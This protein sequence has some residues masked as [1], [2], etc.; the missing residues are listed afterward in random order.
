MNYSKIAAL[1]L[2]G[3]QK[4]SEPFHQGLA[5]VLQNRVDLTPVTSPYAQGTTDDDAFFAGRMRGHNEFCNLLKE[6]RGNHDKA[7]ER[8]RTFAD[9]RRVA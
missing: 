1:I 9:G 7:V 8:L 2:D 6:V 3:E 5:A 4:R